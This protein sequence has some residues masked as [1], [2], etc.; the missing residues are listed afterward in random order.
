VR[1]S[2]AKLLV[3]QV[4]LLAPPLALSKGAIASP[5]HDL[6]LDHLPV[7][8]ERLHAE[9]HPAWQWRRNGFAPSQLLGSR[10]RRHRVGRGASRGANDQR[11]A[12][13]RRKHRENARAL[14]V[15]TSRTPQG[16]TTSATAFSKTVLYL[17]RAVT[18]RLIL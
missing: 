11:A 7:V 1:T 9:L 8:V 2:A 15:T 17:R 3:V 13:D 18:I 5:S 4:L 12:D 10:R 14:Y 16:E 6:L